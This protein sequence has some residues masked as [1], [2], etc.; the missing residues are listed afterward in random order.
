LYGTTEH[1]GAHESGVF[2]KLA[3]DVTDKWTFRVLHP[4]SEKS[5]GSCPTGHVVRDPASNLY[6]TACSGGAHGY[7]TVY[8][9]TP[10]SDGT[11]AFSVLYN[12]SGGDGANSVGGPI[13][14]AAGNLYGVTA[15]G[16]VYGYG[17]VYEI[18]P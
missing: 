10:N 14:D 17:A 12:F 3:P 9:M 5:D 13:L 16:G 7:G 2:F 8:K 18:T 1:A 6:G 15:N 11:W 4:F